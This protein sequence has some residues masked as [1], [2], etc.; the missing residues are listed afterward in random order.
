MTRREGHGLLHRV[1]PA[2]AR[3]IREAVDE[4]DRNRI[5]PCSAGDL[6]TATGLLRSMPASQE[7]QSFG[8][9]RLNSQGKE[10][11]AETPPDPNAFR[12]NVLWVG[13]EEDAGFILNGKVFPCRGEDPGELL[14]R[15]SGRR[16][17]AEV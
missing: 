14:R 1:L 2:L 8:I 13:F 4:I 16:A 10:A 17:A 11:D 7:L 5:K 12:S 6:D 15:Q 3:L 9:E